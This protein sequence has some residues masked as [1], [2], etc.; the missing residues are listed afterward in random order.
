MQNKLFSEY[1]SPLEKQNL[2]ID[3]KAPKNIF[4]GAYY[5]SNTGQVV[6]T[7]HYVAERN[8]N[9][10]FLVKLYIRIGR[11]NPYQYVLTDV[12]RFSMYISENQLNL[13]AW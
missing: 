9:G 4:L 8:N 2:S 7:L 10:G 1:K 11:D 13:C 5:V 3:F 6:Y 12:D